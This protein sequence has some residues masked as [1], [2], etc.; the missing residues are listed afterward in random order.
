[1]TGFTSA[2]SALISTTTNEEVSET[3]KSRLS[4]RRLVYD[5]M[6]LARCNERCVEQQWNALLLS[7]SLITFSTALSLSLSLS[8]SLFRLAF[9]K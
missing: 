7:F 4:S 3:A 2:S 6:H 8:L 1:M 9:L 5:E